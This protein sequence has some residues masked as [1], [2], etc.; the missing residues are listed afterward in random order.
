L[1]LPM[2]PDKRTSK[3]TDIILYLCL[4]RPVIVKNLKK[5]IF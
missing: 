5:N 3:T 2:Q 4:F 1:L